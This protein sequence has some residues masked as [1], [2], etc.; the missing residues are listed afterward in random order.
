MKS[1]LSP[2]AQ[3]AI[4]RSQFFRGLC[5]DQTNDYVRPMTLVKLSREHHTGPDFRR[6]CAWKR[7]D[8]DIA[9]LQRSSRS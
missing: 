4:R 1:G 8:Y 7:A 9:R 2:I 3:F 6:V 5:R